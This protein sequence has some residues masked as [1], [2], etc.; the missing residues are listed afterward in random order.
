MSSHQSHQHTR[1]HIT[2]SLAQATLSCRQKRP[3][4]AMAATEPNMFTSTHTLLRRLCD[5]HH[6]AAR[7]ALSGGVQRITSCA[8]GPLK[9]LPQ[10]R[11]T[12][13]RQC[14]CQQ[15]PNTSCTTQQLLQRD[16]RTTGP[17]PYAATIR[18]LSAEGRKPCHVV[19]WC[20][21]APSAIADRP[22]GPLGDACLPTVLQML[23]KASHCWRWLHQQALGSLHSLAAMHAQP[24]SRQLHAADLEIS[25]IHENVHQLLTTLTLRLW[26][27][28]H[29]VLCFS[30]A[31]ARNA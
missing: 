11:L 9:D 31:R 12:V 7:H 14:C 18:L 17:G 24:S 3:G 23:R 10:A 4:L 6:Q 27:P 8:S 16:F 22:L 26:Q 1:P 5:L 2:L 28:K 19:R 30:S 29:G 21:V 15:C 20:S 13:T 25:T